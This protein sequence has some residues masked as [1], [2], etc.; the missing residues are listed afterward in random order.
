MKRGCPPRTKFES[1]RDALAEVPPGCP[2]KKTNPE[3][4]ANENLEE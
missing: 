1:L 3:C 4:Y 2:K